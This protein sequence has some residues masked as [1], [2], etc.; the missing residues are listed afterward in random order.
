MS[1]GGLLLGETESG[2]DLE[3]R[4]GG[5]RLGERKKRERRL[6]CDV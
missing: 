6:G 2:V 1:L 4:E 5:G 3:V